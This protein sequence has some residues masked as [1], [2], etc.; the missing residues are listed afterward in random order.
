MYKWKKEINGFECFV[1]YC[2]ILLYHK[3]KVKYI[4]LRVV[5]VVLIRVTPSVPNYKQI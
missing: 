2:C 3:C 4:V 1:K 5:K